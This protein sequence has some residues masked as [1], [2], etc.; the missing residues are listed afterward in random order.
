MCTNGE[1][2]GRLSSFNS[3]TSRFNAWFFDFID[4]Y[5]S[6]VAHIHKRNA[7]EG[8]NSDTIVELG[9]GTGANFRYVPAVNRP[10]YSGDSLV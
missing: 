4:R 7:F 8:L 3:R 1:R 9:A 5:S 2:H 6:H 10:G